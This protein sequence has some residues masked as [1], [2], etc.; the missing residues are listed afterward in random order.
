MTALGHGVSLVPG[1]SVFTDLKLAYFVI[2][3]A[4]ESTVPDILIKQGKALQARFWFE[5]GAEIEVRIQLKGFPL[6]HKG[7]NPSDQRGTAILRCDRSC[8]HLAWQVSSAM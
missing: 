1:H 7:K 5:A 4:P 3:S 6:I 8:D 2:A